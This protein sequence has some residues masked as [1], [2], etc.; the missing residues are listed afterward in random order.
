[1]S[2]KRND[3]TLQLLGEWMTEPSE[4]DSSMTAL[5]IA[6]LTILVKS[7][8]AVTLTDLYSLLNG[9]RDVLPLTIT[10]ALI[11]LEDK[12]LIRNELSWRALPPAETKI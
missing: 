7:E 11:T 2:P 5:E 3:V 9:G 12:G 6:I 4:E 1:M 8:R 10:E